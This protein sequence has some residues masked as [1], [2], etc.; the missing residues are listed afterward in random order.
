MS[1]S[2]A[3]WYSGERSFLLPGDAKKMSEHA[4]LSNPLSDQLRSEVLTIAHYGSKNSITPDFLAAVQPGLALISSGEQNSYG[5]PNP[6]LLER[7]SGAAVP[8]LGTDTCGAI[9]TASERN[10]A[11]RKYSRDRRNI[12]AAIRRNA[13]GNS[14]N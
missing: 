3:A 7:L 5:H 4:I 10:V 8:T 2:F 13:A 14:Q 11:A 6:Q 9:H 12:A 1:H